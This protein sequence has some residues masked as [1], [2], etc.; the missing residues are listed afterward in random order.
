MG[1]VMTRLYDSLGITASE[2]DL[3]RKHNIT[4]SKKKV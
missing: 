4:K 3:K 2:R 1:A